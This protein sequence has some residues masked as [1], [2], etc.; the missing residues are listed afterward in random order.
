VTDD[1]G[2][3]STDNESDMRERTGGESI[4]QRNSALCTM[5]WHS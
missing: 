2:G 5:M 4:A 1:E 3:E